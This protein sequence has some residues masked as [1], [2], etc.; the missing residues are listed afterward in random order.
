MTVRVSPKKIFIFLVVIISVLLLLNLIAIFFSSFFGSNLVSD[1]LVQF[2]N[3]DQENNF[4]SF[5]SAVAMLIAAFCLFA[6]YLIN[7]DKGM[8][9][10]FI[11]PWLM[12]A[13][14]F[15]F[16]GFDEA[17]QIHE[18]FETLTKEI[19]PFA[20]AFNRA[21]IIPYAAAFLIGLVI[22]VPFFLKLPQST[23]KYFIIS[24]VIFISGAVG[25]EIVGGLYAKEHGTNNLGYGMLYTI[26]ETMEMLG[27][28]IFIFGLVKHICIIEDKVKLKFK[29]DKEAAKSD[30]EAEEVYYSSGF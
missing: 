14:V 23:R 18:S 10:R 8:E 17:V 26:E 25:L 16:L 20:Q 24:G 30:V 21:W 15:V 7:R 28:A 22:F 2:F 1:K 12:L 11:S 13:L 9:Y 6:I 19:F 4:P 3:F 27:V 29:E 5:F